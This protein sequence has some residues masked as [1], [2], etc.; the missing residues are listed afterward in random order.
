MGTSNGRAHLERR[1]SNY[2]AELEE[3]RKAAKRAAD[4]AAELPDIKVRITRLEALVQ[5]VELL[6]REDDPT[7]NCSRAKPMKK[8]SFKSPFPIG[9]AGRMALE[10]LRGADAPMTARE[11][12]RIML[13]RVGVTNYER[14]LL[15]KQTNSLNGYLAKHRGDLVES[16]GEWPQKKRV[17]R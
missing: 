17:V 11:I 6:L 8:H 3:R 5:A 9:E 10:V 14:T 15:D 7:W 1:I 12:T 4:A 16:D 13:D 2:L